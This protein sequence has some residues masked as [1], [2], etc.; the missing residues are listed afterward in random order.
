MNKVEYDINIESELANILN[1]EEVN[2]D[3][4]TGSSFSDVYSWL[5][6]RGKVKKKTFLNVRLDTLF[7]YKEPVE[8]FLVRK[9]MKQPLKLNFKLF[10]IDA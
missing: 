1:L 3:V 6:P 5:K 4:F 8:Y 10:R 9:R 7:N 2:L